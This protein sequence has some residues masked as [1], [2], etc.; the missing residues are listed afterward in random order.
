M[1]RKKAR[2]VAKIGRNVHFQCFLVGV[3]MAQNTRNYFGWRGKS[4]KTI[5]RMQLF[6]GTV[7]M[8]GLTACLECMPISS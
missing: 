1:D 3:A 5:T 8:P 2:G 7:A 6:N 4:Q